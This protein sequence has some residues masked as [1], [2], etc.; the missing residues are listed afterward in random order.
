MHIVFGGAFNGKRQFVQDRLTGQV[1]WYEEILPEASNH[2]TVTTGLEE[3]IYGQLEQGASEA[4]I[5]KQVQGA[6]DK[7]QVNI[8]IWILTDISRGIVPLD[9]LDRQW[10]DA[11]GRIY[12]LLFKE[13][14][15]ITR[16]WY[17][18]PENL[19]GDGWT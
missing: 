19:K 10:R 12:Q 5:V 15:S 13:A 16:I 17:G 9:P 8:H 1:D 7:Q 4:H 14:Q 6:L 2:T 11:T 18:L 3:W